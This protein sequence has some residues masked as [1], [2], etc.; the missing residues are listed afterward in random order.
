[1]HEKI[2]YVSPKGDDQWTGS[3]PEPDQDK[4][5]G[6]LRT[7]E[8]AR[9]AVRNLRRN[10]NQNGN[11][12]VLI[13]TGRYDIEQTIVF[14]LEDSGSKNQ[15]ISYEAYPGEAPVISGS[16]KE[17]GWRKL[18]HEIP[19]LTDEARSNIWI[20]DVPEGIERFYV[21]YENGH[22]LLRA[23][24]KGFKPTVSGYWKDEECW[25]KG[26][27]TQLHFPEG[28]LR[29]WDNIEDVEI[30]IRPWCL[31]TMNIL[32]L[33]SV[34]TEQ[35]IA[36]TA[37]EGSYFLSRERYN[38]FPDETVWPENI[39]EG[40]TGP[41]RWMVNTKTRKI[42]LWPKESGPPQHIT[43]P[44]L[45]ELIRIEGQI[46]DAEPEDIPV[47]YLSFT[48]LNFT[49]GD[50]DCWTPKH[51]GV[52]HDWE[53][54]D[55]GNALV[56]LRGAEHCEVSGCTF[57]P[58]GGTGV[59][60]DLHCRCNRIEGNHFHDLGATG[61]FLG[62]YGAG[63]K[64]VNKKNV[65][66]NNHIHDCGRI[67][68]HS[69]GI[70]VHQS[71]ENIISHN[72]LY[73]LPYTGIV[74]AGIR[75]G[76]LRR[77][78]RDAVQN[79]APNFDRSFVPITENMRTQ[80]I[81]EICTH[82]RWD[83][84]TVIENESL[85]D[86]M[87]L[88]L[89]FVHARQN[90]IEYN[91]IHDIMQVLADGNGIY[92]SDCGPYNVIRHNRI[93]N[94]THAFGVGIRTD[95]WQRDTLVEGNIIH[96]CRGGLAVSRNNI[97]WNN[98]IAFIRSTEEHSPDDMEEDEEVFSPIYYHLDRA[99]GFNDGTIQRNI[100]YHTGNFPI[101]FNLERRKR[102]EGKQLVDYN[103]FYWRDH[104]RDCSKVLDKLR[105]HGFDKNSIVE[106]P[107]FVDAENRDFHLRPDSRA[108]KM[109]VRSLPQEKIGL[110]EK[111]KKKNV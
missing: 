29:N 62:G 73:N 104:D 102:D 50:R 71:G 103:V 79:G 100:C 84:V 66:T 99:A 40:M 51:K 87:T 61:I 77:E 67:Y 45:R 78:V 58:S 8:G 72:L 35:C 74:L 106:D 59:R 17:S 19:G 90:V 108:K 101:R 37:L 69:L 36:Q 24:G 9:N 63:T 68:W 13:R 107:G 42:Y 48:N 28:A 55:Q 75:P 89:P 16:R 96:D 88:T 2:I 65:I 53:M 80:S 30:V 70:L 95:A 31:W 93:Y 91:E 109:G 18:D 56:R 38:R 1:M 46:Q 47:R 111:W 12:K 26:S 5:D 97:A 94:M 76:F 92:I 86:E 25:Q 43:V 64:D 81:R 110:Q 10:G 49:E 15:R 41:G 57:G 21:L 85:T 105:S 39:P 98:V 23:Q 27:R 52:Q 82:V 3:V 6:P 22:P 54:W 4:S 11:I 7:I 32:P 34:D 20:A 83:E 44:H 14:T 33:Q 60:L